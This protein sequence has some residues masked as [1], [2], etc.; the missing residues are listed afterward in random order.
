MRKGDADSLRRARQITLHAI[1]VCRQLSTYSLESD[2]FECNV[3]LTLGGPQDRLVGEYDK[4]GFETLFTPVPPVPFAVSG[5]LLRSYSELAQGEQTVM[6]VDV[7][8]G[9]L[10]RLL[11][12]RCESRE[13]TRRHL[14]CGLAARH[15]GLV[16]HVRGGGLVEVYDANDLRLWYD[17]FRWRQPFERLT[18]FLTEFYKRPDVGHPEVRPDGETEEERKARGEQERES[19]EARADKTVRRVFGGV[20]SLID[21]RASSILVFTSP[22][23]WVELQKQDKS[24]PHLVHVNAARRGELKRGDTPLDFKSRLP[25]SSLVNLLRVDGAHVLL[26][27]S[28]VGGVGYRVIDPTT[29]DTPAADANGTGTQA[30][31]ELSKRLLGPR[32]AA[33]G[34]KFPGMVVKVSADRKVHIFWGGSEV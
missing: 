8:S 33:A 23:G 22:D 21:R 13:Y 14:L 16:V 32:A 18:G 17:G 19:R 25:L 15:A 11:V 20:M 28:T 12:I 9:R 2:P 31:Q 10:T 1:K 3:L 30:A 4:L 34:G 6:A 26:G 27:D 29:A 7:D 5:H 24:Q